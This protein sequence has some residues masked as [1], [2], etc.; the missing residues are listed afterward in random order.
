MMC[1]M[2]SRNTGVGGKDFGNRETKEY[3]YMVKFFDEDGGFICMEPF[4]VPAKDSDQ[5]LCAVDD[6]AQDH[7]DAIGYTEYDI[8]L[9]DVH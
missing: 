3:C 4:T 8:R 1:P 9:E 2:Q 6:A 7:C 5:A